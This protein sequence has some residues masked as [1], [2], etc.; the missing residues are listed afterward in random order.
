MNTVISYIILSVFA[1]NAMCFITIYQKLN[2]C[3]LI[4]DIADWFKVVL[5]Y[6]IV[7]FMLNNIMKINLYNEFFSKLSGISNNTLTRVY[8]RGSIICL[9]GMTKEPSHYV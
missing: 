6:G 2:I 9:Q 7:E 4:H 5:I 3:D 8:P 1:F